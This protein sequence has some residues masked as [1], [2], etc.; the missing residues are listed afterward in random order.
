MPTPMPDPFPSDRVVPTTEALEAYRLALARLAPFGLRSHAA[1]RLNSYERTIADLTS[2][3]E[4]VLTPEQRLELA[5]A[6]CEASIMID[7]ATLTDTY[8][9]AVRQKIQVL[10]AGAVVED[11][12]RADRAR[13]AA[14]ELQVAAR[15]QILGGLGDPPA[16]RG[17][18]QL[19]TRSGQFPAEVKR[20][21]SIDRV[22]QRVKE[23]VGQLEPA[24][25]TESS[26]VIVLDVSAA[27][28]RHFGFIEAATAPDFLDIADQQTTSFMRNYVMGALDYDEVSRK[29][30]LGVLVRNVAYGWVGGYANVR[31]AI[32]TQALPVTEPGGRLDS[33]FFEIAGAIETGELRAGTDR[34]MRAAVQAFPLP[35]RQR[36]R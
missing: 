5:N 25:Q 34:H 12:S 15:S 14:V 2:V 16:A 36:R 13:D 29:G 9:L 4:A 3:D 28:R 30:V 8:L 18:V 19:R 31:R 10:N 22:R 24:E 21:S 33:A 17:D 1:D 35:A 26:G 23:A 11:I 6:L 20:I 32:L 27:A 7:I